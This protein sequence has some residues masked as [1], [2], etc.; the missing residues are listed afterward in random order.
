MVWPDSSS[1]R[2]RNEGSSFAKRFKAIPIFSWSALVLG[3]TATWI[4]G[5]GNSMRSKMIGALSSHR[6]S[7]VVTSFKPM[8]AAMSPARTSSI[9]VRSAAVIC[10]R[11]P[12]RSRVPFTELITVSPDFNT[13]EYTRMNVRLPT[14]LSFSILNAK[15][16]NGASSLASRLSAS[17]E[18]GFT[19][20]TGGMSVGAG[21]NSTTA[22]NMRCTPLFLNAEPH[23]IGWISPDRVRSRNAATISSSVSSSPPK[24]LSINSSLASAAASIMY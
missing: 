10:T 21:S 4:T 6:V 15:A 22:S 11:R 1:V 24:Y 17:S 9:S 23:N 16:E 18:S 7:P 13:P 3:S 5:S 19:P 20:C 14:Y 8:A 12:I 2:T